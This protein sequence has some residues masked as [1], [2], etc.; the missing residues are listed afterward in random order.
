MKIKT[1]LILGL[2]SL[3]GLI[4]ILSI[5]GIFKIHFLSK[6]TENI[7]V[8]N[9]RTL[10]YTMEM[11]KSLDKI[12]EHDKIDTFTNNLTKQQITY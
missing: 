3:F 6:A 10:E 12:Q 5:S 2:G 8:D 9:Y 4:I 1:K 11:F 7:I